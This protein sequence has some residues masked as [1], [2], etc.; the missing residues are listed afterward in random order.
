LFR[1]HNPTTIVA[2]KPSF[3]E[4]HQPM[5]SHDSVVLR[6]GTIA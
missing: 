1:E 2:A 6:A 3:G 4:T 5:M